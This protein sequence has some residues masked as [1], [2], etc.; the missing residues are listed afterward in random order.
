M[1]ETDVLMV[2]VLVG[3]AT[4]ATAWLNEASR[5]IVTRLFA[6]SPTLIDTASHWLGDLFDRLQSSVPA[7]RSGDPEPHSEAIA[8][9]LCAR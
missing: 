8:A 5:A 2:M 1:S 4:A 7:R 9:L 6:T 3:I